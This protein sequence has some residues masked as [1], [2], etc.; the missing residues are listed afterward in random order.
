ME[1]IRAA[2]FI[3]EKYILNMEKIGNGKYISN[4]LEGFNCS[5][6][7]ILRKFVYVETSKEATIRV[8]TTDHLYNEIK[9]NGGCLLCGAILDPVQTWTINEVRF[10]VRLVIAGKINGEIYFICFEY[11]EGDEF[12][13]KETITRES[14]NM[15]DNSFILEKSY[16]DLVQ[17]S[18][19]L[20]KI[21]VDCDKDIDYILTH[22][23]KLESLVNFLKIIPS[24]LDEKWCYVKGKTNMFVVVFDGEGSNFKL[25]VIGRRVY[26]NWYTTI[27]IKQILLDKFTT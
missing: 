4:D 8:K 1:T 16:F 21:Y 22:G 27:T 15:S 2:S 9:I 19:D 10:H 12:Y 23:N 13:N 7:E 18:A 20:K 11:G 25:G 3:E 17:N 26:R 6:E 24:D 14:L 5:K